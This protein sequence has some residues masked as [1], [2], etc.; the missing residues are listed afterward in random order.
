[1]R[2]SIK[3][4]RHFKMTRRISKTAGNLCIANVAEVLTSSVFFCLFVFR[5]NTAMFN[6]LNSLNALT[7][8][9][10]NIVM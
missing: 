5:L 9:N 7:F 8:Q 1:M 4:V 3:P 10:I 6:A 2:F